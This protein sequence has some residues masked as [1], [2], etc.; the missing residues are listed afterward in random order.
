MGQYIKLWIALGESLTV[1]KSAICVF[2]APMKPGKSPVTEVK[3]FP[4]HPQSKSS[5]SN[6]ESQPRDGQ[7]TSSVA[8]SKD[9][10]DELADRLKRHKL[11]Y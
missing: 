4:I 1:F 5:T 3:T 8:G 6:I 9:L 11:S 2:K 10:L 7:S